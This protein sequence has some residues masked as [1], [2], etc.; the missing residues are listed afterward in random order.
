ME[1][2]TESMGGISRLD[3]LINE[4]MSAEESQGE[5]QAVS[6]VPADASAL[7]SGLVGNGDWLSVLPQL[8][9][10]AAPLLGSF[11]GAGGTNGASGGG[12]RMDRHTALLCA[13][14]PYLCAERQKA[15]DQL[16]GLCKMGDALQKMPKPHSAAGGNGHV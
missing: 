2:T 5:V 4:V 16:I 11:L 3:E 7:L 1:S 13:I 14:K 8:I 6:A 10:T 9:S 15:A 12:L